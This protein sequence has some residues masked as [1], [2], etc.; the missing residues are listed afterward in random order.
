[1]SESKGRGNFFFRWLELI[2]KAL[3]IIGNGLMLLLVFGQVITRYVFNYTPSFG[4][5]LARYLFVWVVF[6]SLPLV[7]RYGGHMAIETLTSRV[8]GATLK[9]LNIMADLFTIAFL[10]IM[11]VC[12]IQMVMRTSYQTSPAMMIP[13]SWVYA[14]IPFGCAVMLLYVVMNLIDVLKT[15]ANALKQERP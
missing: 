7:A 2:L 15:P 6:L 10:A 3:V 4:E 9:F 5:E 1:M 14:V 13:M 11:V 12:G 8:H